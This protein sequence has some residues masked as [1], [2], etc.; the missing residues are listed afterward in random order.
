MP[1]IKR[2]FGLLLLSAL[3]ALGGS[4]CFAAENSQLRRCGKIAT[5]TDSDGGPETLTQLSA[6]PA[7]ICSIDWVST[8]SNGFVRLIDSPDATITNVQA[9]TVGEASA[10][11]ALNADHAFY[12]QLGRLTQFGII[13][14]VFQ[15]VAVISY[16]D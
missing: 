9:V 11:T 12:G 7:V 14:E 2:A 3:V 6:V 1:V 4:R 5:V 13:A 16:D 10:A 8:S 15:G